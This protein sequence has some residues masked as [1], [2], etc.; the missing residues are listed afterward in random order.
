MRAVFEDRAGVARR[1]AAAR[2]HLHVGYGQA[3]VS[4]HQAARLRLIREAR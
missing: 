4:A 1:V 3:A 2:A